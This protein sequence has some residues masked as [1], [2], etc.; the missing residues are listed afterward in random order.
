MPLKRFDRSVTLHGLRSTFRDWCS[1]QTGTP[2]EVAEA[3]LAHAVGETTERA[4]F[5]SDLFERRRELMDRWARFC[6][7]PETGAVVQLR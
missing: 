2:Y 7:R 5:R 4:Y 3:A 1:E 6:A